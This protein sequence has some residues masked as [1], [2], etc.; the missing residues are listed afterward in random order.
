MQ[1]PLGWI[2]PPVSG[3]VNVNTAAAGVLGALPGSSREVA[4]AIAA[5]REAEPFASL[6][7]VA[8]FLWSHPDGPQVFEGMIDHVTTKSSSFI[9][10]ST[11][12]TGGGRA[13]CTLRAL[14]RRRP[15]NVIVVQ[16]SELDWRL[17]SAQ[18]GQIMVA[19]R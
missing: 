2:Y 5:R 11:G 6:T 12:W 3:K 8:G 19:R 1:G 13:F 18:Q 4:E 17:P 14:V 9:I 16:Q 15:D 10:E 7:D